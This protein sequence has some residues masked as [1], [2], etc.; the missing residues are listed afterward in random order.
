MFNPQMSKVAAACVPGKFHKQSSQEVK[1]H[2]GVSADAE[3]VKNDNMTQAIKKV[4]IENFPDEEET[5]P[6][7][8]LYKNLWLE[9]E[10]ALCS[11]T[12]MARFTRMKTE[13]EK[14]QLQMTEEKSTDAES[15]SRSKLPPGS[16]TFENLE[17]VVRCSRAADSS[18]QDSVAIGAGSQMTDLMTGF[19]VHESMSM[20][21]IEEGKLIISKDSPEPDLVG[22]S[23]PRD[24]AGINLDFNDFL[25]LQINSPNSVDDVDTENDSWSKV[26]SDLDKVENLS[27]EKIKGSPTADIIQDFPVSSR[28]SQLDDVDALAMARFNILKLRD[29]TSSS[30]NAEQ[31]QMQEGPGPSFACDIT[32]WSIFKCLEEEKVKDREEGQTSERRT[33]PVSESEVANYL[34]DELTVKEFY[35]HVKDDAM[36]QPYRT[37]MLGSQVSSCPGIY[38]GSSSDWEHV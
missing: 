15:P 7:V 1:N 33:Q 32:H 2:H 28:T 14:G 5:H 31:Q 10:A 4:L 17:A 37:N 38:D 26:S 22:K 29:E 9:A 13:M 19:K 12:Y 24:R 30:I 18:V 34:E 27:T 16:N 36:V 23:E 6:Q 11:I 3:E 35:L 25:K 20:N 8:L 21:A